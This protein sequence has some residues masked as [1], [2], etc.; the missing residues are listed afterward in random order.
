V[1]RALLSAAF[2]LGIAVA[3]KVANLDLAAIQIFSQYN[4]GNSIT[5]NQQQTSGEM[6]ISRSRHCPSLV[7]VG[8]QGECNDK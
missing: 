4:S 7:G 5:P 8:N 2:A 3:L 6:Q 1:E